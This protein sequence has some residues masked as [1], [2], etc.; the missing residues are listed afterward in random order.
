LT[1]LRSMPDSI[2]IDCLATDLI[3]QV[4]AAIAD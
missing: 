2:E 4:G 3:Q 1:W